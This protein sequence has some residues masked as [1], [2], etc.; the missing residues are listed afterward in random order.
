MEADT[1]SE[2]FSLA[3][4]TSLYPSTV[5]WP[6]WPRWTWV[7]AAPWWTFAGG[8]GWRPSA[9]A[10]SRRWATWRSSSKLCCSCPP[11]GSDSS[12]S[13]GRCV[14]W[15]VLRSWGVA[16][17][18]FIPTAFETGTRFWSCPKWRAAAAPQIFEAWGLLVLNNLRKWTLTGNQVSTWAFSWKR[19]F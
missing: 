2:S 3:G 4:T 9:S 13:T 16:V 10:W 8:R 14:R 6:R 11:T 1:L 12:T 19:F 7:P 15:W 5:T 18:P 17:G